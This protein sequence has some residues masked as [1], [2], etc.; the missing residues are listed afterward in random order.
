MFGH[1]PELLIVLVVA[2]IVFGPEKLPEVAHNAGKFVREL[3]E[4]FDTVLHPEDENP[5]DDFSTYYYES[6]A[7][8]GEGIGPAPP[9]PDIQAIWPAPGASEGIE[10]AMPGFEDDTYGEAAEA[11][12]ANGAIPPHGAH[13]I[14]PR[15]AR[16]EDAGIA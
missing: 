8:S 16:D 4:S 2:L 10:M 7:R 11:A 15:D 13:P 1:L 3:R 9:D 6:L 12:P 5:P 14:P